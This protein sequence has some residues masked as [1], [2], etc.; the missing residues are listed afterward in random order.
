[1]VISLYREQSFNLTCEMEQDAY[2]GVRLAFNILRAPGISHHQTT[3]I[4]YYY[5]FFG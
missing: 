4:I 3:N 2:G 1:M 5:Y